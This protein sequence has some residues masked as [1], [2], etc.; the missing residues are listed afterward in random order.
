M[1]RLNILYI[2][3]YDHPNDAA[4]ISSYEIIKSLASIGHR[5]TVL[6]NDSYTNHEAGFA[7]VGFRFPR[8]SEGS[9]FLKFLRCTVAYLP[10]F[11]VGLKVGKE[12]RINCI[13]SQHHQFHLGTLT[14]SVL[15]DFLCVPHVVKVQDGIP[16]RD[17]G[18]LKAVY[19]LSVMKSLNGYALRRA[20][21]I[22][23]LSQELK[24]MLMKAFGLMS[25]QLVVFP[26]TV[27]TLSVEPKRVDKMKRALGLQSKKILIF[28]GSTRWRGI[29][30]LIKALARVLSEEPDAM[31][32]LVSHDVNHDDLKR[33]AE[34][35]DVEEHVRFIGPV[36]HSLVPVL[37]SMATVTIG[38]L[39]SFYFTRGAVPRKV[40]EYM[41]CGRP[42]VSSYGS[43]SQDL[44]IEGYN[45][46]LVTS[47]SVNELYS[48]IVSLL[49]DGKLASKIGK[50]AKQHIEKFY[51]R[52]V[53]LK[54]L[55]TL[56]ETMLPEQYALLGC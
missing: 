48:A 53:L 32:V 24:E 10:L 50:N 33:L 30:L 11:L 36:R 12:R 39:V 41:A 3:H 31:L 18:L 2:N 13:F 15:S 14:A 52:D 17:K 38:P 19:G 43:T 44:L 55:A 8:A 56:T 26:N 1:G 35:L 28:V 16:V 6:T 27:G 22:L 20:R 49:R 29:E 42:V 23:V 7:H 40:L 37:I 4:A 9:R 51:N 34:S 5:V 54:K 45:A 21:Y 47:G 46:I 25:D